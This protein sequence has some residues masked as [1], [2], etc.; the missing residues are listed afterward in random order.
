MAEKR[1]CSQCGVSSDTG[2]VHQGSWLG[3]GQTGCAMGADSCKLPSPAGLPL[4]LLSSAEL[5]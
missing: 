2:G 3:E 4:V 1:G 5:S